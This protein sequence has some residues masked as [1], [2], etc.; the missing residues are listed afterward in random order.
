MGIIRRSKKESK[1][2]ELL[3]DSITT[4]Q[5]TET[6]KKNEINSFY[7]MTLCKYGGICWNSTYSWWSGYMNGGLVFLPKHWIKM[8]IT[9]DI[10]F[11]GSVVI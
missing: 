5:N 11:E 1:K 4:K 8:N 7:L 6:I 10:Y 3:N 2:D 9:N